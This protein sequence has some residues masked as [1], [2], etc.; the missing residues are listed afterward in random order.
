MIYDNLEK[1]SICKV[2]F[3]DGTVFY[4][5]ADNLEQ[6]K[7]NYATHAYAGSHPMFKVNLR[8]MTG[9]KFEVSEVCKIRVADQPSA[10]LER[11]GLQ[12]HGT[13]ILN[14]QY[15]GNS[16]PTDFEEHLV[17]EADKLAKHAKVAIRNAYKHASKGKAN[18]DKPQEAKPFNVRAALDKAIDRDLLMTKTSSYK[19]NNV[20]NT[21]ARRPIVADGKDYVSLSHAAKAL[22]I[23]PACVSFRLSSPNFKDW[24]YVDKLP[25]K[26]YV[27]PII[28]DGVEYDN[29][30]YAA[31]VLG[32]K[33]S[34]LVQKASDRRYPSYH[35]KGVTKVPLEPVSDKLKGK[36]RLVCYKDSIIYNSITE[37]SEALNIPY[38]TVYRSCADETK[39]LKF[40][41]R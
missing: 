24:Y 18:F 7:Q 32:Y 41:F 22:N 40:V 39:G 2:A 19:H 1:I 5:I 33:V 27:R 25:P 36:K 23:S 29:V 37:A 6:A 11:A 15:A 35:Y 20:G 16:T 12:F 14:C 28:I 30:E 3:E 8:L 21:N 31:R 26:T 9:I 13:V 4:D 38:S 34:T 10:L 17:H